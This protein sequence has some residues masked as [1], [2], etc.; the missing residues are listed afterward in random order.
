MRQ[1]YAI[2][3]GGA[4]IPASSRGLDRTEPLQA[5]EGRGHSLEGREQRLTFRPDGRRAAPDRSAD[6]GAGAGRSEAARPAAAP[7]LTEACCATPPRSLASSRSGPFHHPREA[8][9]NSNPQCA[10]DLVLSDA[11]LARA[12]VSMSASWIWR[13]AIAC[14]RR[15]DADQIKRMVDVS[16]PRR[17]NRCGIA[18]VVGGGGIINGIS[19]ATSAPATI[20][21]IIG[22]EAALRQR[23][24]A[25][26]RSCCSDGSGER[27]RGDALRRM[28]MLA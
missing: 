6:G 9:I 1:R 24:Q 10:A 7:A 20:D 28:R 11:D 8:A 12:P 22:E 19:H 16:I 23:W 15:N 2:E 4:T 14:G 26:A 17:S 21:Q 3:A 5:G 13:V 25:R 27:C 18:A